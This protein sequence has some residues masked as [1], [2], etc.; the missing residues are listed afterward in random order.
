MLTEAIAR[1][2]TFV[3][4]FFQDPGFSAVRADNWL[5]TDCWLEKEVVGMIPKEQWT[6]WTITS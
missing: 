2:T 3:S 6:E 1:W 4:F 5:N